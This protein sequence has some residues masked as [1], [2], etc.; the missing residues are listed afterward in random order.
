M[1]APPPTPTPDAV[2]NDELEVGALR[3]A[4]P[5][6]PGV[7]VVPVVVP[8]V[9]LFGVL[10]HVVV[11]GQ[12]GGTEPLLFRPGDVEGG[13]GVAVGSPGSGGRDGRDGSPLRLFEPRFRVTLRSAAEAG[14]EAVAA[15][16]AAS[17]PRTAAAS[18]RRTEP[19]SGCGRGRRMGRSYAAGLRPILVVS[20][21]TDDNR[22]SARGAAG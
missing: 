10:G 15:T 20:L 17:P 22:V 21:R 8:V 2:T 4:D 6:L 16:A 14:P 7:F 3:D 13:V 19:V 5:V 18:N 11:G 9:P 12:S 1:A